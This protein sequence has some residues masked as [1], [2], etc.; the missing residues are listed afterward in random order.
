MN[1]HVVQQHYVQSIQCNAWLI[2]NGP[3][4]K[5]RCLPANTISKAPDQPAKLHNLIKAFETPDQ[6]ARLYLRSMTRALA[7]RIC[8]WSGSFIVNIHISN[9]IIKLQ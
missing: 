2:C 7:A 9:I 5:K 3:R 4:H 1:A 8:L 6:T